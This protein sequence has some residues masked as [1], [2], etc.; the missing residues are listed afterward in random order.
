MYGWT[1]DCVAFSADV[2][3]PVPPPVDGRVATLVELD[4]YLRTIP[5]P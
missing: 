1:C 4:N 2:Y 3:G 5:Y